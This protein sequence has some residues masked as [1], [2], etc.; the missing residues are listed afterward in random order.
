MNLKFSPLNKEEI[1]KNFGGVDANSLEKMIDFLDED[2]N[3]AFFKHSPYYDPAN[4]PSFLKRSESNLI[5]LS[6]NTQSLGSKFNSLEA[7]L[8]ILSDQDIQPHLILVQE[9]WVKDDI[10]PPFLELR[11]YG[12]GH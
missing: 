12:G 4:L 3:C 7:M 6:I 5:A 11:G 10:C 1:L 9:S 8:Q 2:N